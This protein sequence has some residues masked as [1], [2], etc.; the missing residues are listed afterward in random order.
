[1]KNQISV[2]LVDD[3]EGFREILGQ[4]LALLNFRI[5]ETARGEEIPDLLNRED[6]DV[7]LLDLKLPG[8][9]GVDCLKIIKDTNP[10]IEVIMLTAYGTIDNAVDAMK[11]GAYYYL[12]KPCKLDEL[13]VLI[14]KAYEKK[15]LAERYAILQQELARREEFPDII[16]NS[17]GLK[18]VLELIKK[19]APTDSTVLIQGDSG[20]GK[21]LVARAIH[22]A[23]LRRDK[24]FVVLDCGSLP[25]TLIENELFG[26]E[27]GAYTGAAYLKHGLF[28]VADTGTL[29]MDE[30]GEITPAI[31]VKLLRVL[32][33]RSFRRVGST[34]DIKVD[35][36]LIAATNKDLQ[37]LVQEGKFREELFYRLNV[38]PIVIPTLAERRE[39]IPLL[40]RQFVDRDKATSKRDKE[41]SPEAMELLFNYSW[42]GN[43]RELQNVIERALILSEDR[44]I[45]PKDLPTNLKKNRSTTNP[46]SLPLIPLEKMEKGYILEVLK[47]C[48]GHRGMASKTLQ[49]SESTLYRRLKEYGV[50]ED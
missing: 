40:A 39:D 38:F 2:L 28:E 47:R 32:E 49:I 7:V 35:I 26:H 12:T 24:P 31:Q 8:I 20:V 44:Y 13:E 19:V 34:K 17:P 9:S 25:E 46:D 10:S 3:E 15:Q 50:L 42:P 21:E 27:K 41:I 6:I 29:F 4:E 37:Q 14:K 33:A 36:R 1:M 22:R 48:E 30:I 45:R 5:L 18:K 16:G 23:S 43:I 11:L